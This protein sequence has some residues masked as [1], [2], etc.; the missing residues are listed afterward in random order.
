MLTTKA[1][2]ADAAALRPRAG[3][4]P[5]TY[6][7]KTAIATLG[8]RVQALDDE[9]AT[10]ST[11]TRRRSC[12]R[13]RPQLLE[14]YGVGVDTA[15]ILLVAAGDNAAADPLRSRVGAPLRRRTHPRLVGQ[16]STVTDSTRREPPSEPC[17]VAD[18]VHPHEQRPTHPR[19]RR[20]AASP[21]DAPNPRSSA[22]SSA[23][24][25]ARST[26]TSA[27]RLTR[28]RVAGLAQELPDTTRLSFERP[29]VPSL[30]IDALADPVPGSIAVNEA[31][32]CPLRQAGTVA[33]RQESPRFQARPQC[34]LAV[35]VPVV[36]TSYRPEATLRSSN[37]DSTKKQA[38][39]TK[40]PITRP[41]A[42]IAT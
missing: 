41:I 23:T 5:V 37:H 9:I 20:N 1:L 32:G 40:M 27:A 3:S 4:D 34:W 31:D 10:V 14:V 6:A 39:P 42:P 21:R 17:A 28:S 26:S 7:T 16:R 33:A 22:S 24:S 25:P 2:I 29:A 35:G 38:S 18:R 36:A 12:A 13:P 11:R 15:A 8:R 30:P 19:L